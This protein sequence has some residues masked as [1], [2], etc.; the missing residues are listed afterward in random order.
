M[1]LHSRFL[2]GFLKSWGVI[3]ASEIGD[4]TFLIAAVMAMKHPRKQVFAGAMSAL[5]M[6]TVLSAAMGWAAPNLIPAV[7]THYAA[8]A[9][10]FV[11]GIRL[12]WDVIRGTVEP[13]G[14]IS[15]VEKE[16]EL[17]S[18][19]SLPAERG[20]SVPSE[21]TSRTSQVLFSLSNSVRRFLP[22]IVLQALTLTFLAEWGD[23]SQI[24]TIG[25]ATTSDVVGVTLGG[26]LGHAMCTGAAVLGGKHLAERVDERAVSGVGGVLFLLFGIHSLWSGVPKV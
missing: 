21:L 24:A 4:K 5:A 23:R 20:G 18:K 6:M 14:D 25:L 3:L 16:L 17:T 9:L 19:N 26:I 15:E 1:E 12:L 7:Y 8:T 13:E 2:E 10:F 11:F 22:A